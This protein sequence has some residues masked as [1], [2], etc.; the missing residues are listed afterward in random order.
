MTAISGVLES[1]WAALSIRLIDGLIGRLFHQSSR[2]KMGSES[3]RRL[4]N[5]ADSQIFTSDGQIWPKLQYD[6]HWKALFNL[7]RL[8]VLLTQ[9]KDSQLRSFCGRT[10][11]NWQFKAVTTWWVGTPKISKNTLLAMPLKSMTIVTS[12]STPT[13]NASLKT[14]PLMH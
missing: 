9:Q 10:R 8:V 1:P 2:S 5:P 14:L 6:H 3:R 4:A 12:A 11:K 7:Y 13:K